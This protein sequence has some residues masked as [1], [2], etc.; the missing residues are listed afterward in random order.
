MAAGHAGSWIG[1]KQA[2]VIAIRVDA[3]LTMGTGH[4]M[5]CLTLAEALRA[6]GMQCHFIC[7]AHPG[8]LI[9]TI[10]QRGFVVTELP[11]GLADFK[12]KSDEGEPLPAHAHWIGCDWRR[13]AE[14]TLAAVH[15]IQPAWLMIDHYGID[16]R[17]EEGFRRQGCRIMVIDDLA[18]RT[19]DCD[20]LLDQNFYADMAT[21]YHGLVPRSCRMLL[22]PMHV[23]LRPEFILAKK[24]SRLRNGTVRRIL[25]FFG[26]S[27]P[28]NQTEKV[29]VALGKLNRQEIEVDVVIGASNPYRRQLQPL[30]EMMTNVT[31]RCEV[32]NMA[33]LIFRADLGIGAGGSAMWE[34]L[35]LGLPSL[36]VVFADNQ[37]RTTQ[38]AAKLG[39]I[40]YL[41]RCNSFTSSEYESAIGDLLD[42]PEQVRHMAD[43]ASGLVQPGT[44]TVADVMM[45]F[46]AAGVPHL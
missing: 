37:V 20:L 35:Y 40:K 31:L 22:G 14:Q 17:W 41:G 1:M 33:E 24:N 44:E 5:R 18:D 27:D 23:L 11:A 26:G 45:T 8:N 6:R 30:C 9:A 46:F 43:A 7:R 15:A 42:S 12:P 2:P 4:V 13:D 28:T 39:V 10:R 21:R 3:S 25:V 32:S 36:T 16:T 19:H 29:L 34:R 38:D